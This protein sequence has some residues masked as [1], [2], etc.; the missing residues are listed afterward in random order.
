MTILYQKNMLTYKSL[1]E[2]GAWQRAR[3]LDLDI[4]FVFMQGN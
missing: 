4:H 1:A 3:L 2:E